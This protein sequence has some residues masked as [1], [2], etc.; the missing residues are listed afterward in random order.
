MLVSVLTAFSHSNLHKEAV[1]LLQRD[2]SEIG[3]MQRPSVRVYSVV[4]DACVHA[5][6]FDLALKIIDKMRRQGVIPNGVTWMSVLGPFRAKM[7]LKIAELAF[8]EL[9]K[10][11]DLEEQTSAFVAMAHIYEVAGCCQ[12]AEALRTGQKL[13]KI[14][15]KRGAVEVTVFG[16]EHVFH[17]ADV[18][19]E[20]TTFGKPIFAKL[21]EWRITLSAIGV[22]SASITYQHS[23][24]LALALAVVCG[25]RDVTLRKICGF[26]YLITMRLLQSHKRKKLLFVISTNLVFM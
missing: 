3:L 7:N 5:G 17:V 9:R 4:V 23:E 22:S 25:Q 26:V 20:L 13:F 6:E 2:E 24:K 12:D 21:S 10:V 15:K 8:S 11:R 18:P 19:T 14:H 1:S 16:Q